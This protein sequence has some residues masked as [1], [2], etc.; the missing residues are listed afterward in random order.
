MLNKNYTTEL[1]FELSLLVPLFITKQCKTLFNQHVI[2]L[3]TNCT[4]HEVSI[5]FHLLSSDGYSCSFLMSH[6]TASALPSVLTIKWLPRH[7]PETAGHDNLTKPSIK[8]KYIS[9]ITGGH[10]KILYVALGK[11]SY[12][13]HGL[14][15]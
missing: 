10:I 14:L 13:M 7:L 8:G 5:A 2:N 4:L 15:Q 6:L 9:R 12:I 3:L 11:Y 1:L